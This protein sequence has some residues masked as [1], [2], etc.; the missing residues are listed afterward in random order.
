MIVLA[1]MRGVP[2]M[3]MRRTETVRISA[4]TISKMRS[5]VLLAGESNNSAE[6]AVKNM[7]KE[8]M[9]SSQF[10]RAELCG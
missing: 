6:S 2:I 9:M 7:A 5:S 1:C 8:R 4:I 3:T 10:T